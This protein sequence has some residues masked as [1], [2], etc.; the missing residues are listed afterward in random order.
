MTLV[1]NGHRGISPLRFAPVEM[2][3]RVAALR[4]VKKA[5]PSPEA[6]KNSEEKAGRTP[7]SEG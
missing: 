6:L 3:A 2:T 1:F 4:A 7:L 5:T